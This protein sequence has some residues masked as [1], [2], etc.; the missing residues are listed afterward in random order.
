M[1][2]SVVL[3][4]ASKKY[5]STAQPASVGL[6]ISCKLKDGSSIINPTIIV[7]FSTITNPTPQAYNM[8]YISEFARYYWIDDVRFVFGVWEYTLRVDVLASWKNNIGN[9]TL[10]VTRSSSNYD[11]SIVDSFYPIKTGVTFSATTQNAN[12]FATAFGNG[13]FVVGIINADSS[14]VGAVSYYVFTNTE[15]R[16]FAA[17]LLG[18]TAYWGTTEVSDQLLKCLYNPFQY[19][20][21]C[22][23]MPVQPPVSGTINSIKV[24]WWDLPV[25]AS[26][27]SATVR[28]SGTV[29]ITIPVHPDGNTRT[30]LKSEPF[31]NYYLDFPPFG[32]FSIPASYLVNASYI[33]FAWNVDSITGEG[34]LQMG[35]ENS[36]Q[37]FNIVQGQ[38]GIP[39]TLS[40][41]TPDFESAV[42]STMSEPNT[43]ADIFIN[44]TMAEL[45]RVA[46]AVLAA[47]RPVQTIGKN[48]GFSAGYYPIKLIGT[49]AYLVPEDI[50]EFGR[51]CCKNLTINTLSGYVQCLH[52]DVLIPCTESELREIRSFLETGF[53]YE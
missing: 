19:V 47:F 37:P 18:N 22:T 16:A 50:A 10:Y 53:F 7:D 23:W 39:V 45:S 26:R 17:Y 3:Y 52:G 44:N 32:S 34:K 20:V 28:T 8:A 27:L 33:D 40:Q 24:G 43:I 36:A 5:N 38:V 48:G 9:Q 29:T 49:F 6:T 15:F 4:T 41:M 12:P 21:S 11:T 30:F 46:S 35:A 51:P 1:A 42:M 25:S 2:Y 13:Y 14:A 31:T